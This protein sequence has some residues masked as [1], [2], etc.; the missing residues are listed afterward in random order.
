MVAGG[1]PQKS[2]MSESCL[3]FLS[4][5][6]LLCTRGGERNHKTSLPAI[7]FSDGCDFINPLF[8]YAVVTHT[9][10]L[11]LIFVK[12]IADTVVVVFHIEM[13]L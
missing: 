7:A 6:S 4:L 11:L 3:L 5:V 13:V 10:Y 12:Q 2:P 8:E 9:V 1:L